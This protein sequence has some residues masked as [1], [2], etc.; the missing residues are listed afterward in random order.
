MQRERLKKILWGYRSAIRR[1]QI[2]INEMRTVRERATNTAAAA[3]DIDH[4]T[5][6]AITDRTAS[7]AGQLDMLEDA[8]M[9]ARRRTAVNVKKLLDII[10]LLPTETQKE[11]FTARYVSGKAWFEISSDMDRTANWLL[12]I[13]KR[14]IDYL[15]K[16]EEP[17]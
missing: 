15:L 9:D 7:G 11:I 13:H 2:L 4:V 5:S 1:E 3:F 10:E 17:T 12:H 14:G 6:S 16:Q 8:F